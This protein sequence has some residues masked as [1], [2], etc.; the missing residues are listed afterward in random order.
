[1]VG[2]GGGQRHC[3]SQNNCVGPI[4]NKDSTTTLICTL[5]SI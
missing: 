5:Q 2:G 1:M 3:Q 4:T